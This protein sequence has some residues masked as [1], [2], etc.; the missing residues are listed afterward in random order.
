MRGERFPRKITGWEGS[1]DPVVAAALAPIPGGV[2]SHGHA[3]AHAVVWGLMRIFGTMWAVAVRSWSS[4]SEVIGSDEDTAQQQLESAG[5]RGS[6]GREQEEE[7]EK[8]EGGEREAKI[9]G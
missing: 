8:A 7:A 9:G 1:H 6:A 4:A 2:A 3:H 5:E